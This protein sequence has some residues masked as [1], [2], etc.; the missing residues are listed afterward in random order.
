[1]NYLLT[2]STGFL[3]NHIKG[4]LEKNGKVV[5]IGR[6]GAND[7][8]VL[9][10]TEKIQKLPEVK[11]DVDVHAAGKAH[12]IPKTE[13]EKSSFFQ[14]NMEGTK[15]LCDWIN[16]WSSLPKTFIFISTVAVYGI[17]EG[18]LIDESYVNKGDSP[19]A[20]SKI[21]AEQYLTE[22]GK[23]LGIKILILRLP[24]IIGS[25]PPGNLGKMILGIK[26]GTYFSIGGGKARKSM[27][28]A[29]DVAKLISDCPDVSGI[30]NLTDG[31]HPSFSE[32]ESIVCSQ[33]KKDK[34][35]NMPI[36]LAKLL[37]E[38]GD[39]LPVFPVNSDTINKISKDL[40]FSDL[41][42]RQELGWNPCRVIDK[43]KI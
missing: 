23:K 12:M 37:G 11:I 29:A 31:Y 33:L 21:K 10:I 40:T 6:G 38:I 42:A 28:L 17:E 22:W 5:T 15:N 2:G 39:F 1:M 13:E 20:L 9:S 24:L 27:V 25:N 30:Y 43:F 7:I 26:R 16:Q 35:F 14:I 36:G 41:K 32:L 4:F 3:G 34:P 19:Y 8:K 18:V